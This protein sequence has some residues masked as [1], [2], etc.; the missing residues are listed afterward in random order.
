VTAAGPGIDL[1][2]VNRAIGVPGGADALVPTLPGADRMTYQLA[3]GP[4]RQLIV[5]YQVERGG[6]TAC[7]R[8]VRTADA[9]DVATDGVRC[10]DAFPGGG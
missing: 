7:V 10:S 8:L 6:R 9:T 5:D 4:P 1:D 3:T 2:A